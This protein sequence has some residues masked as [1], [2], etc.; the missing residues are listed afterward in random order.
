[1]EVECV[2]KKDP[3]AEKVKDMC[4][5]MSNMYPVYVKHCKKGKKT[6]SGGG[7]G[8][9][10]VIKGPKNEALSTSTFSPSFPEVP[11]SPMV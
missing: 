7:R 5:C 3:Q 11:P 8:H 6:G 1:M 9:G 2:G 10:K 4:D